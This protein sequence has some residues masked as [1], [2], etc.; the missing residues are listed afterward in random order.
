M[1]IYVDG[2]CSNNGYFPN[3]G[4]F[5]LVECDDN[6]NVVH[7]FSKQYENTTNNRMEL[8]AILLALK[9]YGKKQEPVKVY[10]DSAYAFNTFT[11]WMFSWKKK[12]WIKSNKKTPENLDIVKEYYDLIVN[13]GYK[14][15]L[16]K[17]KGHSGIAGNELADKLAKGEKN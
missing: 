10:T 14:I 4:G 16:I 2:S 3:H 9:L 8:S 1:K 6:D 17:L 5:G 7:T 11:N 13:K 12:G 15:D